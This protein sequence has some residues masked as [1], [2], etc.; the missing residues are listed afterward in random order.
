[1]DPLDRARCRTHRRQQAEKDF[2][3][4]R[5]CPNTS[6]ISLVTYLDRLDGGERVAFADQLSDLVDEQESRPGM[7]LEERAVLLQRLPLAEG[8]LGRHISGNPEP[9][10]PDV[11][12]IPVKV[13]AGVFRDQQVGGF[14]G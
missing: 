12:F 6:A 5:G 10:R 2:P 14:E 1:M 11:R 9:R 3:L 7:T 8:Y 13:L 4:L